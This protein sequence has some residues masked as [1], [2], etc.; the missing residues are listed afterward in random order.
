M[1]VFHP[2]SLREKGTGDEGLVQKG[3]P[4]VFAPLA[5]ADC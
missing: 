2:F 4:L 5:F 1:V 3:E